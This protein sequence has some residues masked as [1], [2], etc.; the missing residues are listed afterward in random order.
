MIHDDFRTLLRSKTEVTDFVGAR[1]YG[2]KIDQ[3][4]ALP[5]IV[6]EL[7]DREPQ[8]I[9]TG[10]AGWAKVTIQVTA[11]AATSGERA[12]LAEAIR[13]LDGYTGTTGDTRFDYVLLDNESHDYID[14]N[15][16]GDQGEWA[17]T[18]VF[19]VMYTERAPT[20]S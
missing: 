2:D 15:D 14:P 19:A 10:P 3:G 12:R 18:M 13:Q 1:I 20:F 7:G 8:R 11:Y 16:S 9:L 6:Y 5:R 4:A 17:T